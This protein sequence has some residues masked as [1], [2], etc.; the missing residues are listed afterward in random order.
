[1]IKKMI[2]M[3]KMKLSNIYSME[4]DKIKENIEIQNSPEITK[5][6]YEENYDYKL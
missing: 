6:K 2:K 4:P 3:I 5:D 1:M